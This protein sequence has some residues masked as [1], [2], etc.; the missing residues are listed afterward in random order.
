MNDYLSSYLFFQLIHLRYA[1][2][3]YIVY[4][5]VELVW[6]VINDFICDS[7]CMYDLK[8]FNLLKYWNNLIYIQTLIFHYL[9]TY[10]STFLIKI[11]IRNYIDDYIFD[12][13]C[14]DIFYKIHIDI[15]ISMSVYVDL[16]S[17]CLK[18]HQTITS[19]QTHISQWYFIIDNFYVDHRGR[20]F[21]TTL[22]VRS[23]TGRLQIHIRDLLLA[24][25]QNDPG[26]S[27]TW[28][29]RARRQWWSLPMAK[30]YF[31]ISFEA[32]AYTSACTQGAPAR[33]PYH[34]MPR[35]CAH[36]SPIKCRINSG[37]HRILGSYA[38][39]GEFCGESLLEKGLRR[40]PN[41][42]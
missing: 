33:P 28:H 11:Y 23:S 4:G 31:I 42:I 10:I 20:I 6:L 26:R 38:G 9:Y 30:R 29:T 24:R 25:L 22:K 41:K 40:G 17:R 16:T 13:A 21:V 18:L 8:K 36:T 5:I 7:C 3:K 27:C 39:G 35:C 1:L 15:F 19:V 37:A 2:I 32:H 34:G 14:K 12:C